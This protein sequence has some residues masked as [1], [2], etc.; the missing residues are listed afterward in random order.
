MKEAGDNS[1]ASS[2]RLNEYQARRLR[3]ACHYID[4]LLCEIE[5]MLDASSSRA[6][7]PRYS[8]DLGPAESAVI[9]NYVAQVRAKLE[10][11]LE[12]QDIPREIPSIA[13]SHAIHVTLGT[14]DIAVEELKPRYMRGYGEV[15]EAA[16]TELNRIVSDLRGL[17]AE[18]DRYMTTCCQKKVEQ[19]R[20]GK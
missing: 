2:G 12:R 7:F 20:K 1:T 8:A 17:V 11:V 15:P 14:I 5:G 6:A 10:S 19:A 18:F 4:R 9:E 3:V 13:A 16:V